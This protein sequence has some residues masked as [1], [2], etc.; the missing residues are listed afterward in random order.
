MNGFDDGVPSD[1][2]WANHLEAFNA[3]G[4]AE[5]TE[6]FAKG[7]GMEDSFC[8]LSKLGIEEVRLVEHVASKN[9]MSYLCYRMLT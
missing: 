1:I 5:V 7:G 6:L 4:V 3:A 9:I 8:K 2:D